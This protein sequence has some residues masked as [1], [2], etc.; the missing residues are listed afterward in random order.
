M[1]HKKQFPTDDE[2]IPLYIIKRR[3]YIKRMICIAN[4]VEL[5]KRNR[6]YIMTG[7]GL[8]LPFKTKKVSIDESKN[9][10]KIF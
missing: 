1:R 10:T 7:D 8:V 4:Q 9:I 5:K 3:L 2:N 6:S